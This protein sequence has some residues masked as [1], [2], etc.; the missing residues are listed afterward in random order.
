MSRR[1]SGTMF[2]QIGGGKTILHRASRGTRAPLDL[3]H[4]IRRLLAGSAPLLRHLQSVG[5]RIW[6]ALQSA[7]NAR[8]DTIPSAA[9][10]GAAARRRHVSPYCV[11]CSPRRRRR[12]RLP[13]TVGEL[14]RSLRALSPSGTGRMLNQRTPAAYCS[15]VTCSIGER[16]L[17][18]PWLM[19]D[20]LERLAALRH[21]SD[22]DR[23]SSGRVVTSP[24]GEEFKSSG[25]TSTCV[26]MNGHR[27]IPSRFDTDALN[28]SV[29]RDGAW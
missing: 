1:W 23:R 8:H 7:L 27:R 12:Q 6:F 28:G 13:M 17:R 15:V 11:L 22:E 19:N 16:A 3:W 21:R 24:I 5:F 10:N 26:T 2:R 9:R 4:V 20:T 14:P 25:S 18:S 29:G